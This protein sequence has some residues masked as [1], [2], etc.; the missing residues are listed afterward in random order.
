MINLLENITFLH[1]YWF[2]L[3]I[4]PVFLVWFYIKNRN[5]TTPSILWSNIFPFYNK[6]S[7]SYKI[8]ISHFV[9][10]LQILGII[11]III[12]LARPQSSNQLQNIETEVIDIV[13]SMD[14]S[15][16]MLAQDFR[17]DRLEA[18]K[19]IGIE[20]ISNRPN[21]RIGLVVF[22][23]TSFTQCPITTDHAALI[24]L[25]KKVKYGLLEDGTAIGDGLATAV[26]RLKDSDAKS[27]VIILITDGI[28]NAGSIPPITAAEIAKTYGIRVYTIGMGSYG[29]APYPVQTPYGVQIYKMKVEID[30]QLLQQIASI[31]GGKYF[32]ATNNDKLR[33]IYNEIDKLE[34]TKIRIQEYR[35]RNENFHYFTSTA[36]FLFLL[37]L[38]LNLTLLKKIP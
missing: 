7:K 35:K 26:L 18:G 1:P 10:A 12:A 9:F 23:A 17:P 25:F 33:A 16:S 27:K 8:Y 15:G 30:E 29:E 38:L 4:I 37:T 14:I 3:I 28:N 34:K 24:N 13:I 22:S 36:S 31:T 20:F 19:N 5:K 11:L 32:R 6:E 21:D 2:I